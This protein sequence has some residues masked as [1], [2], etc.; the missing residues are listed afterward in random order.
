MLLLGL[1]FMVNILK[2][3]SGTPNQQPMQGFTPLSQLTLTDQ[4]QSFV[5][6][7]LNSLGVSISLTK[8]HEQMKL[9][10]VYVKEAIFQKIL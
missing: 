10:E 3:V 2:N 9:Q 4:E 8:E 6:K 5:R 7:K 1:V